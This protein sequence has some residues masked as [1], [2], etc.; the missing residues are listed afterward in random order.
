MQL[1]A[2]EVFNQIKERWIKIDKLIEVAEKCDD[3]EL[4]TTLCESIVVLISAILEGGTKDLIASFINDIN[5]YIGFEN[6][7]SSIHY[8]FASSFLSDEKDVGHKKNLIDVFALNSVKLN[9]EPFFRDHTNPKPE[10]FEKIFKNLGEKNFFKKI[11]QEPYSKVFSSINEEYEEV[12]GKIDEDLKRLF[13]IEDIIENFIVV[14]ADKNGIKSDYWEVFLNNLV[15]ERNKAAHGSREQVTITL[16]KI[17]DFKKVGMAFQYLS[18]L[19]IYDLLITMK[20][21]TE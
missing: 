8:H 2:E 3:S 13:T 14:D 7:N 12:S 9:P 20:N 11:N 15:K 18:F 10:T 6:M 4:E 5:T 17:K 19:V 21:K 1:A 16:F